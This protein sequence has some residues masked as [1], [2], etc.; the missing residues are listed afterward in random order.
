MDEKERD[1]VCGMNDL[2]KAIPKQMYLTCIVGR[3][4]T[5]YMC[6]H[7]GTTQK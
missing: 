7:K 6:P 2:K 4:V 5:R 1:G 3:T